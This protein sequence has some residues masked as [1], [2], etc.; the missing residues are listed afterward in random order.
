M[1][2]WFDL[3]SSGRSYRREERTLR[4]NAQHAQRYGPSSSS[5]ERT[6]GLYADRDGLQPHTPYHPRGA[7]TTDP[8]S[9]SRGDSFTAFASR[10]QEY[11]APSRVVSS[12]YP[13]SSGPSRAASY[14]YQESSASSRVASSQYQASLRLVHSGHRSVVPVDARYAQSHQHQP[15]DYRSVS[16][17]GSSRFEQLRSA[18]PSRRPTQETPQFGS[19]GYYGSSSA[20]QGQGPSANFSS[21]SMF[22]WENYEGSRSG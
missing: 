9:S 16:P 3:S 18:R 5:N 22:Y 11:S 12:Q 6:F 10:H 14:R 2:S 13:A 21:G 8:R 7:D 4:A 1:P 17:L 20:A 19:H 15:S